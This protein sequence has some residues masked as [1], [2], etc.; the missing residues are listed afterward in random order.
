MFDDRE[1]KPGAAAGARRVLLVK[2]LEEAR[3]MLRRDT[4]ACILDPK[5]DAAIRLGGRAD[6]DAAP[7]RRELDALWIRLT[8]A[9]SSI[10]R[11][12]RTG[13]NAAGKATES[14]M[15]ARSACA[16]RRSTA[17]RP[18]S[19]QY[20]TARGPAGRGPIR[21]APVRAIRGPVAVS[22]STSR[23]ILFRRSSAIPGTSRP[24][25][26]RVST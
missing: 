17:L 16:S 1:T 8:S 20:P 10:R 23:M 2:A 9:P 18:R 12:P 14:A 7:R 4:D 5:R 3:E 19:P 22:S 13:G 25:S 21:G 24:P 11:S 26:S 15:P 6:R